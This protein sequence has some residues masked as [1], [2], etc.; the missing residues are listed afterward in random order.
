VLQL[1]PPHTNVALRLALHFATPHALSL[2]ARKGLP[3][4]VGHRPTHGSSDP[5][6][7][8]LSLRADSPR[9]L[10][11]AGRELGCGQ[12]D[13]S[14]GEGAWADLVVQHEQ[15]WSALQRE[16][17]GSLHE[18][19]WWNNTHGVAA[20]CDAWF[21]AI[22][23][24]TIPSPPPSFLSGRYAILA[25]TQALEPDPLDLPNPLAPQPN[26]SNETVISTAEAFEEAF[27]AALRKQLPPLP[28]SE[29]E[30]RAAL[31]PQYDNFAC[32]DCTPAPP[33][34]PGQYVRFPLRPPPPPRMLDRFGEVLSGDCEACDFVLRGSAE[35]VV[36]PPGQRLRL[37][38][39]TEPKECAQVGAAWYRHKLRAISGFELSF[40]FQFHRPSTC[41]VPPHSV[42]AGGAAPPSDTPPGYT[43]P[44]V[45]P[46]A[47]M[48][49]AVGAQGEAIET[50]SRPSDGQGAAGGDCAT[51]GVGGRDDPRKYRGAVGGEG[52]ALLLHSDPRGLEARGCGG[53]G[54][55]YAREGSYFG[56]CEAHIGR[57]VAVQLV[58]HQNVTQPLQGKVNVGGFDVGQDTVVWG[59]SE[60]LGIYR[61]GDNSAPLTA[62]RWNARGGSLLDGGAHH[63]R[64][65][66]TPL[67]GHAWLQLFLDHE[68]F[69]ALALPLSLSEAGVLDETG[70]AW[71]G[72]T[73]ST[74]VA[75]MDADLLSFAFT[76]YPGE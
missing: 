7:E 52:L 23:M 39:T 19:R 54:L 14:R 3:P 25:A 51:A 21:V 1:D 28:I 24:W 60:E 9:L 63:V 17:V 34:P 37:V 11:I 27:Q 43:P 22:E 18:W 61:D 16:Q 45:T 50:A 59:A 46:P 30:L 68:T 12:R 5:P 58:A 71:V 49:T 8:R 56:E 4:R 33:L 55:G 72:F 65:K 53:A 15:G 41:G 75:S 35:A 29:Y 42:A 76:Q 32:R 64:L 13:G 31:E 73:A 38:H 2:V 44:G 69:P 48:A 10:S 57:S 74:G 66:Y 20:A 6:R 62:T 70:M 47:Y 26:A 67:A 40:S 36:E